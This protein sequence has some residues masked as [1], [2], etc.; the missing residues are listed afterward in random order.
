MIGDGVLV[1]ACQR[2][3]FLVGLFFF[4]DKVIGTL[5]PVYRGC[6]MCLLSTVRRAP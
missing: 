2:F 3:W 4:R 6:S 1:V 5:V